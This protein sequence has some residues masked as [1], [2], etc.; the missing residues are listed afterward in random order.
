MGAADV[1]P[2]VSG[3]TVALLLGIYSRLINAISHFDRKFLQLLIK[4]Q[5][6]LAWEHADCGFVISLGAGILSGVIL[7]SFTVHSL[8]SSDLLRPYTLATFF[9]MIAAS[10]LLVLL[11]TKQK[12]HHWPLSSIPVAIICFAFAF[13]LAWLPSLPSAESGPAL[14]YVFACGMIAICAMILP[15]ISGAMILLLLG[16]Y[17][18]LTAIPHELKDGTNVTQNGVV[19]IIFAL[20][21]AT[22]LAVFS[23][24]LRWLLQHQLAVTMAGLCGLMFGSLPKLWPFQ[25]DHTPEIAEF[26]DKRFTPM[27][28]SEWDG[29]TFGALIGIVLAAC[30]VLSIHYLAT[31]HFSSKPTDSAESDANP[32]PAESR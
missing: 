31:T 32:S 8:L 12:A 27:W 26:E 28:P 23:R 1:V 18:S 16:L 9:G 19:L 24:I 6:R 22:G 11:D 20:G 15:G 2:G 4:R 3:G 29:H 7:T 17:G 13:S 21:C 5:W 14:W 30:I 10:G 25:M